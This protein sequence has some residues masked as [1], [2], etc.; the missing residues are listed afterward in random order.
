MSEGK[1]A[2][3]QLKISGSGV[4]EGPVNFGVDKQGTE[5]EINGAFCCL[6][7]SLLV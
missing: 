3:P 2:I 7:M 4:K 5:T 6:K 1:K